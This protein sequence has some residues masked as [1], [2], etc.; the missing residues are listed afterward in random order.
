VE[1]AKRSFTFGDELQEDLSRLARELDTSEAEVIRRAIEL[2]KL[3][4]GSD[5]TVIRMRDGRVLRPRIK[6]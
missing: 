6:K 2:A 1:A 3:V 4:V 5:D